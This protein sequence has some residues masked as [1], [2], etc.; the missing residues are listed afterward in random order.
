MIEKRV[1]KITPKRERIEFK[2]EAKEGSDK[3]E[4]KYTFRFKEMEGRYILIDPYNN[5]IDRW[6]RST[7]DN[8]TDI[9]YKKFIRNMT[10]EIADDWYYDKQYR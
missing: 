3:I 1:Y 9:D 5:V 4:E 8:K 10:E 6:C 7:L 2:V